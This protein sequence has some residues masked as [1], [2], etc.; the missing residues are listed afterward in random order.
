MGR[1]FRAS[2]LL[3]LHYISF[4]IWVLKYRYPKDNY[5]DDHL[6]GQF[7]TSTLELQVEENAIIEESECNCNVYFMGLD[8]EFSL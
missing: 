1:C 5:R 6:V 8:F 4:E 3:P 2:T 7:T